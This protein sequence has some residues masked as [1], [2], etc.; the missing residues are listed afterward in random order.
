MTWWTRGMLSLV[1]GF[2]SVL[3]R[4]GAEPTGVHYG[5]ES[6]SMMVA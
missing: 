2:A 6:S 1:G 5:P 3:R 4:T